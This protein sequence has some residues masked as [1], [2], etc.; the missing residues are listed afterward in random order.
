MLRLKSKGGV[1]IENKIV[2]ARAKNEDVDMV[3]YTPKDIAKMFNN[4]GINQAYN[5]FRSKAFPSIK[6][7]RNYYIEKNKFLKWAEQNAGKDF[8][9]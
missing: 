1:I 8:N 2:K 4:M 5:L 9:F 7:N 3:F 6:M